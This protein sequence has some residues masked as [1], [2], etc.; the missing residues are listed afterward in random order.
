M[1]WRVKYINYPLHFQR[2]ESEIM[3]TV[4]TVLSQGDLILRQQTED[5][6]ANLAAF[7]G[8]RYA[9][10][11]SNCTDALLLS[12]LAAGIGPGDEVITVSHTFVATVAMI[13]QTGAKPVLIDIG[14]DHNMDPEKI[15]PAITSHTKAVVPVSLNG[16]CCHFDRIKQI[17]D[18]HQLVVIEDSAQA[19]GASYQNKR[20]GSW[21]LAG[22]FS[23]YPAKL[24]GAFG[25]AGAVTTDDADL[26]EK[27]CLLRNHGRQSNGE[28]VRWS[29]N[30]RIDNLHAAILDLKLRYL[31]QWIDRRRELA[32][33]YQEG[34]ADVTQVV[35]PPGPSKKSDFYD[36]FQNYELEALNRDGLVE[37]LRANG[38][39][40]LLPWSGKGVHQFRAL[41]LRCD[42]LPRTELLFERALMLPMYPELTNEEVRYVVRTVR[43]FYGKS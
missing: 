36:V 5:F 12:Y 39:E 14:D 7:C 2:M 4:R 38:V 25:D 9:I 10:G 24:L 22:A 42:Q 35:L 30:C 8:T 6:E 23:F 1:N 15:E 34:L 27:I 29:F 37:H 32:A 3:Q 13:V 43:G 21:G 40:I 16:R 41:G 26:A 33:Q 18:K 31:P 28:I 17:A 20:A 11:V 19:L